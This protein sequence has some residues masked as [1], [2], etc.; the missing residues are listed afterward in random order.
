MCIIVVYELGSISDWLTSIGTISA[1]IA[2]LY[3]ARKDDRPRAKVKSSISHSVSYDGRVSEF[4]LSIS[5]EIVNVGKIPIHL[6]ECTLQMS[7]FSKKRMAFLDGSNKV[8][9]LLSPGEFYEHSLDYE[10]IY[11]TLK[12]K[13]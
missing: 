5:L 3:L 10:T 12:K 9:K 8:N 11:N 2:A 4:P 6:A 13:M 1:V 7:R